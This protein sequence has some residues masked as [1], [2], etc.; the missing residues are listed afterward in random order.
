MTTPPHSK[1]SIGTTGGPGQVDPRTGS[2]YGSIDPS[3][4]LNR[5]MGSGFPYSET[6]EQK[7]EKEEIEDSD[8]GF[9]EET[10]KAIHK[11]ADGPHDF[12]NAGYGHDDPFHFV[13]AATNI[14]EALRI[15]ERIAQRSNSMSPIPKLY[16]DGIDH[17]G[18]GETN[19]T[20]TGDLSSTSPQFAH[21]K[22][23]AGPSTINYL[24]GENTLDNYMIDDGEQDI[25]SDVFNPNNHEL[26]IEENLLRNYIRRILINS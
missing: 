14:A 19:P 25:D 20:V 7:A 10:E 22:R 1:F 24:Q 16:S 5:P 26:K 17:V 9:D 18:D 13:D 3:Y 2:G 11:K 6:D 15:A 8:H 4:H 12:D 21:N 23:F